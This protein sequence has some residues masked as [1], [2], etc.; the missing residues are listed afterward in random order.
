MQQ[1][2]PSKNEVLQTFLQQL[3]CAHTRPTCCFTEDGAIVYASES[4]LELF[5][6]HNLE[7]L[8][9]DFELSIL[10]LQESTN[11]ETD[12]GN[13]TKT[14][15]YSQFTNVLSDG[16]INISQAH[17]LPSGKNLSL[18][19]NLSH[20]HYAHE[21]IIVCMVLSQLPLEDKLINQNAVANITPQTDTTANVITQ[22]ALPIIEVSPTGVSLW[23]EE[24]QIIACNTVFLDMFG[25]KSFE[26]YKQVLPNFIPELQ[27]CGTPSVKFGQR[28]LEQAFRDGYA[29]VE[30]IW[31]D[32]EGRNFP[33]M[34]TLRRIF[35]GTSPLVIGYTYDLRELQS[36]KEI[37]READ[38]R[39]QIMWDS[40]PLGAIFWNKENKIIDCN[41]VVARFFGFESRED[42]LKSYR[43][44]SPE[45]QPDGRNSWEYYKELLA[46]VFR[47][48][49]AETEWT[50]TTI[51]NEPMP[52]H[53][54]L[55]RTEYRGENVVLNYISD[56]TELKASHKATNNAIAHNK[57]IFDTVPIGI[58]LWN[59]DLE[60]FNCNQEIERIFNLKDKKDYLNSIL[61][62]APELQP[63]GQRSD[64]VIWQ[65]LN[66]AF[67]VGYHKFE[68]MYHDREGNELPLQIV[69]VRSKFNDENIVVAYVTEL[70]ELKRAEQRLSDAEELNQIIMDSIPLSANIW[71]K[72]FRLIYCNKATLKMFGFENKQDYLQSFYKLT[73]ELQP[74]GDISGKRIFEDFSLALRDGYHQF[75]WLHRKTD[76][77]LFPTEKTLVRA[78]HQGQDIMFIFTRDLSERLENQIRERDAELRNE[79]ML[80]SLPLG[81]HFWDENKNL[82]YANLSSVRLF[83]F[84]SKE[85]YIRDFLSTFPEFQPDGS[86]SIEYLSKIMNMA[87]ENDYI[88]KEYLG[89]NP[90]TGEL[91]PAE[92]SI[93]RVM[94][95]GK[96][97]VTV[98]IRDLREL[99]AMLNE[100]HETE[101]DLRLA[102][103]NAEKSALAKSEFLADISHEIRTPMHGILGLLCLLNGTKL[104]PAQEDY[105][106]KTLFSASNLLSTIDDILDFAKIEAGKLDMQNTAFTLEE[107]YNDI[108]TMYAPLCEEKHITLNLEQA[109]HEA[110]KS[111]IL[112]GDFLRLK[113]VLFNLIHNAIKFTS[114]GFVQ[115]RTE[116][117]TLEDNSIQCLFSV[118]DTGIGLE[119]DE[120]NNIFSAFSQADN[121]LQ[122]ERKSSSL[123]LAISRSLVR[124]MHGDIWVQSVKDQ[125]STFFFTAVFTS[126]NQAQSV[127]TPQNDDTPP[128]RA[129]I[130][131]VED[132][133]M[134]QNLA[135]HLL[136]EAEY[137]LDIAKH[138]QEALKML[139][140]NHYDLILMDIHMPVM[141]GV[142]AAQLIR[143]Q[144]RFE[145]IPI[146]GMSTHSNETTKEVCIT[147]GMNDF[148]AKPIHPTIFYQKLRQWLKRDVYDK[149]L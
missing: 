89:K 119:Q 61:T 141:D 84:E 42:F 31:Q 140:H 148:I 83:G 149:H 38:E 73:P 58:T 34:V 109:E 57:A 21:N 45:Y 17:A 126:E 113:Q 5:A 127:E 47:E 12:S 128:G 62:M 30:W 144:N 116:C 80:D 56:L 143:K 9:K 6:A 103:K 87:Y 33:S 95:R 134:Q 35:S 130:L 37:A 54:T 44:L 27:P 67:E 107:L 18:K 3:L 70:R 23:N 26:E 136:H 63:N 132:N 64:E 100:I 14:L 86:N 81:V 25:L 99:K 7:V 104:L 97:G 88:V 131:L 108:E 92:I 65:K 8:Q 75:N 78:T 121:S 59:A 55:I 137:T 147:C 28:V 15:F 139:E 60:M 39:I 120:L 105:V 19:Y 118:K 68:W 94:Y 10:P 13:H 77:K 138:G 110:F 43:E 96:V 48:G 72:D 133:D 46:K 123:G 90:F 50:L 146:I 2:A 11:E 53:M 52:T 20:I 135:R 16:C 79:L 49:Y 74:S 76:G 114:C 1:G 29:Y 124:M 66:H 22:Y 93:K 40:M 102:K 111:T 91:I 145:S 122:P 101:M 117:K 129:Y 32:N 112:L 142:S 36:I 71:D 24:H 106:R 85:D 69:L 51:N 4:F 82:I 115:V 41:S 125:G 98:Y